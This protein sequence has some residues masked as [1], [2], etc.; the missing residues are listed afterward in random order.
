V[1]AIGDRKWPGISKLVEECGEVLQVAGKLM[2]SRGQVEHWNVEN[3]KCALEDE[4]AD[5]MAACDFVIHFCRLRVEHIS[6]RRKRKLDTFS[7]WHREDP[8]S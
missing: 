5:L 7:K 3:L 4:I 2:G 6:A 8:E 1:F